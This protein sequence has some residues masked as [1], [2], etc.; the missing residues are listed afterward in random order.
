MTKTLRPPSALG[1]TRMAK[2]ALTLTLCAGLLGIHAPA[3]AVGGASESNSTGTSSLGSETDG[4]EN[5]QVGSLVPERD[6][7]KPPALGAIPPVTG[8]ENPGATMGQTQKSMDQT[9]HLSPASAESAH[10]DMQKALKGE[11]VTK[12]AAPKIAGAAAPDGVGQTAATSGIQGMDVSGWQPNVNW[13]SEYANGA[14]FAYIK[15][16]E[17]TGYTSPTFSSQYT[18]ASNA[19]MYR[20]GY[21]FALPSQSSGAAQADYFVNNGGGWTADGRTMPGMLDIEFNPYSSLG[22]TCYNMSQGQMNS[23]IT[24]FTEQY[25]NRTG[26]YPVIYT[27]YSWWVSCTGNT[28]QFNSMPLDI[29]YY[30]STAGPM[31]AG[32]STYDIWQYSASGPYSGDSNVFNGNAAG[33]SDLVRNA[34]YKPVGG[35]SPGNSGGDTGG[36]YYTSANGKRVKLSGAIGGK[37]NANRS[38][39]GEPVNNETCGLVQGGCYQTF[40]NGYTIYWTPNGTG[41]HAVYTWGAI[42]DKWMASGYE[43]FYG[44]PVNEETCGLVGGG[45]YQTFS[46]GYTVYWTPFGTGT[47]AVYT[48]GDIGKEWMAAGYERGYGYPTTERIWNGSQ[49]YQKFSNGWTVTDPS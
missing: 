21:H 34:G 22:N 43:R 44:Y 10:Q 45:C 23:W 11:A 13:N 49:Y 41:T 30:S 33:L 17:G 6:V 31:P 32:W 1:L 40:S 28:N 29:S 7:L 2:G 27:N 8:G 4:T 36:S 20:G 37:W 46:N 18:G 25:K 14:R 3:F 12:N 35:R 47:H 39:Y 16:S 24:S 5:K 9:D 19:G 42:G 26:R 48:W 15:A 38:K